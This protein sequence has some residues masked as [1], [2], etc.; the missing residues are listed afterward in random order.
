M[1]AT[2][3]QFPGSLAQ[4]AHR[5]MGLML[6]TRERFGGHEAGKIAIR[7]VELQDKFSDADKVL[8]Q[9]LE[10]ARN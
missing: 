5:L 7:I 9:R 2:I 6:D 4:E 10:Y 1:T 3:I 8:F